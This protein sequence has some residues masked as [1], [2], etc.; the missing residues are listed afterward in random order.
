MSNPPEIALFFGRLHVLLV[1][2]PIGLIVLLALLEALARTPRFR[3]VN[4]N[5][6]VI[7]GIAVPL[8]I[9]TALC[10]WLLSLGGGYQERL[11][12]FH[13]WTG[14]GT[15]AA[16]LVAGVLY[17]VGLMKVYRCC[18]FTSLAVLIVASHF[19][20]SLTHGSDYLT[21]YAPGPLR[22][23]L[24]SQ[25]KAAPAP[26]EAKPKEVTQIPTFNGVVL[27]I[28]Q[29]NCVSCHG[30]QKSKGG[31]RLDSF[32]AV[33]KGGENGAVVV[34]GK[35]KESDLIKRLRLPIDSDDHMPPQGKP[36]PTA[37]EIALI[38]WWVDAG[39]SSDKNIGE[40]KL[41]ANIQ[42]I[43]ASRFGAPPPVEKV[44][45][46]KQ[47]NE[48]MPSASSL[49]DE[50][51]VPITALSSK[52]PWLQCNASIAGTNFGNQELA[53]LSS[54]APNLRWLDLAGTAVTDAGLSTLEPMRNLVRL[55]LERTAVTDSGLAAVAELPNLEYLNLYSTVI[56]DAGLESLQKMPKLKQL[57][58]WQTKV[59]PEAGKEFAEARTDQDQ[60]QRWQEEIE[61]LQ[62]KIR[63]AHINVDVGSMLAAVP[64]TNSPPINAECP[65]SGKPI[66][67]AKTVLHE[68]TLIAFCC[69]DCK[70]KFQ[71]DPKPILA[72]LNLS[73]EPKPETSK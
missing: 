17:R 62:A 66:D 11:L 9:L 34:P 4:V 56:T 45:N 38:Q 35:A 6:G 32:L 33:L 12:Q 19:G 37:D 27:P 59:S 22:G 68:G 36:Q 52:E 24:N 71:K 50:L 18:L 29:Q 25:P 58:L 47:L 55:H 23:W 28:L 46:P 49:S 67:P 8:S 40:L 14:I 54:L 72:K 73:K 69:D 44:V 57:Y 26:A 53:K 3:Q 39:A 65:V 1:H 42:R 7:L 41:P 16:L 31:L 48:I 51:K 20:G 60:L 10:G 21:R 64:S 63:D 70:A 43:L 61:K 2:L 15:A 13:K 5:V 30:P